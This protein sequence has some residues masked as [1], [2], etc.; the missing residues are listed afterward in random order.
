MARIVT[1]DDDLDEAVAGQSVTVT[2]ADEID[3]SR[4]DVLAAADSPPEGR[5]PVRSTRGLDARPPHAPRA[6]VPDEDRCPWSRGS[7]SA[8]RSTEINVNTLEHTAAKTLELNEIGVC[9]LNVARPI[10]FDPYIENR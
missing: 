2:L 8:R 1:F 9:N 10:P 7:P 6:A 5:R 4:G 3:I